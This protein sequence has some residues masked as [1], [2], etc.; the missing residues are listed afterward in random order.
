MSTCHLLKKI[1]PILRWIQYKH[2]VLL[3]ATD[4]SRYLSSQ[5][6]HCN[7]DALSQQ[8]QAGA[9]LLDSSSPTIEHQEHERVR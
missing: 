4:T 2:E 5:R 1:C 9:A 6:Y 7:A 8:Q 3:D